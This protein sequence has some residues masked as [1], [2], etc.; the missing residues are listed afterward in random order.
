MRFVVR[1][2]MEAETEGRVGAAKGPEKAV[3]ERRKRYLG[4]RS[5]KR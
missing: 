5:W 2:Q 3:K 1:A 4:E